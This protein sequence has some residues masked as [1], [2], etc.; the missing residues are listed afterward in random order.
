[1]WK[2]VLKR[3]K[4]G[5]DPYSKKSVQCMVTSMHCKSMHCTDFLEY[6]SYPTFILINTSFHMLIALRIKISQ[7][8]STT[9]STDVYVLLWTDRKSVV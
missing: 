2:E 7:K 1:M 6:G 5:Y 8:S 3:M 4:V 9:D